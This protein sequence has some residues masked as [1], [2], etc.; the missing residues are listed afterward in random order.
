MALLLL[1]LG[2]LVAAKD[3]FQ[4]AQGVI[5][6]IVDHQVVVLDVVALSLIHI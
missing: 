5:E 1:S 6:V 2:Q 4:V 3:G